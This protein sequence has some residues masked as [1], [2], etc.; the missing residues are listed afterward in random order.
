[1]LLNFL[2]G[3][4]TLVYVVYGPAM[5]LWIAI[6]IGWKAKCVYLW[7]WDWS[8]DQQLFSASC[9]SFLLHSI[10]MILGPNAMRMFLSNDA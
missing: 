10:L 5:G 1:V 3:V 8:S 9:S 4:F 7:K 6:G 2:F